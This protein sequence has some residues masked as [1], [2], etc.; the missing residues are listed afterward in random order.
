MTNYEESEFAA[1]CEALTHKHA[2]VY[3]CYLI[4]HA[5]AIATPNPNYTE[6]F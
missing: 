3:L 5:T 2:A 1:Y 4:A 6:D